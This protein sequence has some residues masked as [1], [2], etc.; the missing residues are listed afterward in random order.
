MFVIAFGDVKTHDV[1]DVIQIV[2]ALRLRALLPEREPGP[3]NPPKILPD[4]SKLLPA[5]VGELPVLAGGMSSAGRDAPC[6][7]SRPVHVNVVVNNS[8]VNG[9]KADFRDQLSEAR[10]QKTEVGGEKSTL[11]A[12]HADVRTIKE[13]VPAGIARIENGVETVQKHVRGVPILQAELAEARVVPENL[14]LEIQNRIADILTTNDQ[15][16]WRAVRN[17]GGSQ[18]NALP[19]LHAS[20]CAMSAATLSRR[21]RVINTKL[22]THGL[23]LCDAPGPVV[24]FK[25]NGGQENDEGMGVPVELS[26][27]ET[28]WADDP[29]DRDTTIR[30]YLG[31]SAV[32]RAYFLET[33]PGIEE[34]ARKYLKRVRMESGRK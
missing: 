7:E 3:L 9:E 29:G 19:A 18:K 2:Q 25:K 4:P 26:P 33:K 32:D 6:G 8:T 13:V 22:R 14:A 27:V 21:V 24:R 23:P 34:E 5:S 1:G 20:G 10:G 16:I 28:D 15:E 12:I 11:E 30:A 31:A 17:A